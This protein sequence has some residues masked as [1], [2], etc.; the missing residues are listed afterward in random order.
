MMSAVAVS[1]G[2]V[3]V[4]PHLDDAVL[5]VGALMAAR[6][7]GG[8]PVAVWTA[9]TSGP[10]ADTVPRRLRRF[11]DYAVRIA[12]DDRA[13]DL[14]GAGRRR[15]GLQERLWRSPPG[16]GLRT[17]FRTPDELGAFPHLE[18]LGSLTRQALAEPGV[19]LLAPFG[20]GHHVDHVEVAL[21][22]LAVALR[23]QAW[24]RVGFYE[25]FYALGNAARRQ[26]PVTRRDVGTRWRRLRDAPGWAAPGEGLILRATPLI[27]RGPSLERYLPELA[28]LD[29]RCRSCPVDPGTERTKLAAIA[30]YRSQT[31][32]LGGMRRLTPIL[33]RA[34][35]LRGGELIWSVHPR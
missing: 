28:E 30:E 33:R 29:W 10:A 27:G 22:V 31:R 34:H 4:S 5:S 23:A 32:A 13:L 7:R 24:D 21:A 3:V 26:H 18:L 11:A 12:E 6:I 20:I 25:D 2:L 9:F 15:F 16:H 35:R 14:L 1:G 17:A 19:R 8:V